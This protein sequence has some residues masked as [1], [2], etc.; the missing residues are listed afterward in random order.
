MPH[1]IITGTF[2]HGFVIH[3]P[4]PDSHAAIGW[5][6][7]NLDQVGMSWDLA[8]LQPPAKGQV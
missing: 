1:V 5:A 4:F 2:S 6:E 7:D 8:P 3:G